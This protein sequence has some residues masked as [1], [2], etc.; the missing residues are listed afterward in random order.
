MRTYQD[1]LEV[2]DNEYNRMDFVRECISEYRSSDI[3]RKARTAELYA[4]K[5]NVTIMQYQKLLYTLSG[6]A[7][8]DNWSANYKIPSNFFNRFVI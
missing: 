3:Y 8:P 6:K 2:G 4:K 1:L 5:Q 7:V